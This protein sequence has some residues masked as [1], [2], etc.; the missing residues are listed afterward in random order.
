MSE[1]RAV[2]VNVFTWKNCPVDQLSVFKR[3]VIEGG[4]VDPQTLPGL[5]E[6]ALALA[7]VHS[8]GVLGGVGAIK[9]PYDSHR[10]E[11]FAKSR[12]RLKPTGFEFELGWIYVDPSLRGKRLG[13]SLVDKLMPSLKGEA[14]YA[15]SSVNNE[16]MHSSLRRVG[17]KLEGVPYPSAINEPPIQLFVCERVLSQ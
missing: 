13:S 14:A 12:T 17:F 3:M 9:R 10:N 1:E 16:R 7:F 4:Q 15:T 8:D 11:I 6:R 5:I 2:I